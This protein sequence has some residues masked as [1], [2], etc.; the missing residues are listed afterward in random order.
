[1]QII[2]PTL[3]VDKE[4]VLAN[5]E[6]MVNKAN[7]N[8][9][10]L[11]PHFKTHQSVEIGNWFRKFNIEAIAVSSVRMAQCFAKAGWK[12]ITIAFPVNILEI[13]EINKLAKDITLNILVD[14]L[15]VVNF[16]HKNLETKANIWI[17][18]D[19]GY[20]RAGISWED[21]DKI[22]V[23]AEEIK[24]S[25][26]LSYIGI[27]THAGQS[28]KAVSKEEI[29]AIHNDSVEKMEKVKDILT[30]KGFNVEISVGDTP[31][32]SVMEEFPGVD[33]IRPGNFVFYDLKQLQSGSCT[34]EDIAIRL[35]C[36][37]V[38]KC[39]SRS[40]ILVMGGAVHLSRDFIIDKEGNTIFG[41]VSRQLEKGWGAK[42]Q[43]T[44]VS[45]LSQ[46]HGTIKVSREFFNEVDIGDIVLIIPPHACMTTFSM[47]RLKLTTGEDIHAKCV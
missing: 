45:S 36:P 41:Y 19:V 2:T 40:E 22:L 26:N 37:V 29:I 31:T 43:D 23:L 6:K 38:A 21:F 11:R 47:R 34:E 3:L 13:N 8:G 14:S 27:L 5:I 17:K 30:K 28:Y 9:I 12:D 4:K 15:E 10:R 35:A 16:L 44:Y 20:H 39:E 33:E 42:V 24:K 46:E 32:A 7:K 25:G 1:M 18:I